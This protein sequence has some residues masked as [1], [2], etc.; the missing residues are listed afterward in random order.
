[1]KKGLGLRNLGE[2]KFETGLLAAEKKRDN[3]V[4]DNTRVRKL[5]LRKIKIINI[6][7]IYNN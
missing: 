3:W 6:I 4:G 1:M 2:K 7:L 5:V